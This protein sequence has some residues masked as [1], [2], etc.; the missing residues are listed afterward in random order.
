MTVSCLGSPLPVDGCLVSEK[1]DLFTQAVNGVK[2]ID[3]TVDAG[4]ALPN[5]T[6]RTFVFVRVMIQ[7]GLLRW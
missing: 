6:V 4:R 1:L 2:I 3:C 7:N 5:G